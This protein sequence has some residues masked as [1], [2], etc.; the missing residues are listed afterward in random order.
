MTTPVNKPSFFKDLNKRLSDLLTK[1]FPSEKQENKIEW[2]GATDNN[3]NVE[4]NFT[5]K[6]DGSWFGT[7]IPKYRF[8]EYGTT[9]SAEVNTKK[10]YKAEVAVEDKLTSGLKTTL[11]LN[12][13]GE[14]LFGTV[15]VDYKHDYATISATADYGKASGS[16]LK[17]SGVAGRDGFSM[18]ASAEYFVGQQESTLK[19]LHVIVGY[20]IPSYDFSVFGRIRSEDEEEKNEIGSNFFHKVNDDFS[21]GTEVVFDTANADSKPKLTLGGRYVVD[22]DSVVK[23][24]FDTEGKLGFSYAQKFNRN[25][26]FTLSSTVD[27]NNFSSKGSSTFGFTLGFEY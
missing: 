6:K 15:G 11:G 4:S 3:V 8:K 14:D 26:K 17:A 22:K 12:S 27:T 20:G 23:T 21:Y 25:T 19:D 18:G 9:V 16:T 7:F 5:Q 1:E 2:K 10:E 24:K 13:K